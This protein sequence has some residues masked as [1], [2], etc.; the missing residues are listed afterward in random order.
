LHGTAIGGEDVEWAIYS[1]TA[2]LHKTITDIW[3]DDAWDTQR[4][5]GLA[6]TTRDTFVL[7]V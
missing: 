7:P 5:R 4:R 6:P 1:P 2:N 3:V